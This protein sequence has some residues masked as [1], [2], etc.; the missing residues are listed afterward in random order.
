MS[1]V[2]KERLQANQKLALLYQRA[3][4]IKPVDAAHDFSHLERVAKL[5]LQIYETELS[6]REKRKPTASEQDFCIC[7]ALLHDC[8]PVA[9]NSP[10]RKESSRLA[11]EKTREWLIELDFASPENIE[12]IAQAVLDHSY[13]SGR[14]PNSLL[15]QALQDA[16]RLES[17]GALGLYRTIATGVSMGTELFDALDPWAENRELN[18]LK[19]SLDHFFTKLLKL[20]DT[21]RTSAAQA[22]AH[23][24]AD[25][26]RSFVQQLRIEITL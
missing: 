5:T 21:F 1:S 24:R 8:V 7:A 22:E 17:L 10:L 2:L 26:L 12:L 9:K 11:S 20:P 14:V 23:R 4:A 19:Y 25:F 18:D 16:D 15:G 3:Q 6:Q 13:S